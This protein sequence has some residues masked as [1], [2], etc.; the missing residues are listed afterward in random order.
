MQKLKRAYVIYGTEAYLPTLEQCALSIQEMSDVPVLMYVLGNG[1]IDSN[2]YIEQSVTV[3]PWRFDIQEN[4]LYT[5][6]SEGNFYIKR[7]K[8][9]IYR[10]L[11]ERIRIILDALERAET[12][13]Y[14]DSDSVATENI[15]RIFNMYNGEPYVLATEGIYDWMFYDGR[16]ACETK[17]DMTGTLEYNVCQLFSIDQSVRERYR[18]TNLFIAGQASKEF[19]KEWWS[20]AQHPEIVKDVAKYTPYH[21]ET[22]LNILLWK[23]GYLDG[24]PY[25]YMNGTSTEIAEIYIKN[26]FISETY[27]VAEWVRVPDV[28]ENLLV[29]HGEKR[30]KEMERM[31]KMLK[32]GK[33]KMSI[34]YLAPHLSTGGMPAFLL[35][36]LQALRHPK[37]ELI[38]VEYANWSDEYVVQKNQIKVLADAFYTLGENKMELIDIIKKHHVDVVHVE[39]MVEDSGNAFPVEMVNALYSNNRTWNIVETCHNIVFKPDI[40]KKYHPDAYMF[41]TPFHIKTFQNMPSRQFVVEYPIEKVRVTDEEKAKAKRVLGMNPNAKHVLNVGLWTPGKNQAEGID[42]A[43]Q[44]PDV[45]FHFVGNQAINFQHYWKP[46]M[47]DLPANVKVWGERHDIHTFM[48]A[49][50]VFMFNSTWECNP[51]VVREAIS[52]GLPVLTRNLP[53]YMDMF[54]RYITPLIETKKVEQLRQLLDGGIVDHDIPSSSFF[55]FQASHMYAYN[56]VMKAE[57]VMQ[58][59][60]INI[61]FVGQPFLEI[62]GRSNSNYLVKFID[63][64]GICIYENTIK[65]NHWVRL[66]RRWFTRWKVMVWED[67]VLIHDEVLNYENERVYIAFDSSSL[68]DTIAWMPYVD[69]F[70]IKH[71]CHVIVSTFKNFLFKDS[72]PELEFVEPGTVVNHIKGMYSIGWFYDKDREPVLP[73][74]IPLQKAATNILGLEYKEIRPLISFV[75]GER[76]IRGKYVTIATNSTAGCKFWTKEAWQKVI[77]YLVNQKYTIMNVS[78]ED[79]PF[80]FCFQLKD[81]SMENTMNHIYYSE[82]F[83]GLSSGLSW[84]AWAL[85]KPVVMIS[86]FTEEDH[87]FQCIR[88]VNK[89]VCHG[90]WNSYRYRFDKS[91]NW[92]PVHAGTPRMFECQTSITAQQVI[93]VLPIKE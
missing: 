14:V 27:F 17:E 69:E 50:D 86:N 8:K 36:R 20:M 68:G 45:Q 32:I 72:Y 81:R 26:K 38:V 59:M 51:L 70:R 19:I 47:K 28:K 76:P 90:C 23:H 15:D 10:I 44:M 3:I 73:N 52:Y 37:M 54:T 25:L 65:A 58:K 82:F 85:D 87:E 56:E 61:H 80:D 34:L 11:T 92:C 63:E 88:P 48:I 93:D 78:L 30:P 5:K 77:N 13:V 79:N 84:L 41:C 67:G 9:D 29:F 35:K 4:D 22:L 7:E 91:W 75:P 62:V 40:E 24:L 83:I 33:K 12:V 16:G 18:T 31:R 42:I 55:D 57:K 46:L 74:T 66:N 64:S 89:S 39:E 60:T 71:K 49:A 1:L 21:E 53:Q 2:Y 43:R 6:K